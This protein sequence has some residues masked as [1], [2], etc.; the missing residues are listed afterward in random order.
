MFTEESIARFSIQFLPFV[1]AVVFHEYAHGWVANRWGDKTAEEQ[2]RLTLNPA[3]H[4]DPIGTIALPVIL[5]LAQ[6]SVFFGWAKPVP[7]DPSRF[8]KFRPGLFF[9]SIAGVSMN[10]L[11]AVLSAAIVCALHLWMPQ[12]FYLQEPLIQMA[13]VSIYINYAL[14]LFNLI[15]IPPLDGS[16]VIESILPYEAARKYE[17]ISQYG[18]MILMVLALTGGLAILWPPIKFMG[19]LTLSL[20]A[21]LFSL[22]QS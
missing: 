7:I 3:V 19:D 15:P 11:L 20:M 4:V 18:M 6:S 16:K 22:P 17:Q 1:V 13:M 9:V 5:M 10:F 12:D 14:G 8:R 2:G 21:M